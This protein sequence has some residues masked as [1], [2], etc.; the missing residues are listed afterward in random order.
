ME[1]MVYKFKNGV[2]ISVVNWNSDPRWP[3]EAYVIGGEDDVIDAANTHLDTTLPTL[4]AMRYSPEE[5]GAALQQWC[6]TMT[7]V[8]AKFEAGW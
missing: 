1:R 6:Y 8:S 3:V 2:T 7:L 4:D 5:F